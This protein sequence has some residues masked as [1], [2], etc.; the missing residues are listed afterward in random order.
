MSL[1]EKT[2]EERAAEI[3]RLELALAAA[4]RE[5]E[6]TMRAREAERGALRAE[7]E[8]L[9]AKE[10]ELVA[11]LAD[12]N[13]LVEKLSTAKVAVIRRIPETRWD[14]NHRGEA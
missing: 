14:P 11:A 3:A 8:R 9:K 10:A 12:A 6:V 7:M 4:K 13:A 2:D 1:A 5:Q